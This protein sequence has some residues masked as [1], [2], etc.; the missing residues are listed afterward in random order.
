MRKSLAVGRSCPSA[1]WPAAAR[2]NRNGPKVAR[3]LGLRPGRPS[4]RYF[5]ERSSPSG[6][7]LADYDPELV[8][9]CFSKMIEEPMD[10][11]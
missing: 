5:T 9:D 6:A 10:R 2:G 8:M 1:C 11:S 3:R 4:D 7:A